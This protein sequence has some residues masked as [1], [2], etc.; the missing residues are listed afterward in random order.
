MKN[1]AVM[2]VGVTVL[3]KFS[4]Q[5]RFYIEYRVKKKYLAN[6]KSGSYSSS[7]LYTVWT[8]VS[9]ADIQ[10]LRIKLGMSTIYTDNLTFYSLKEV[11]VIFFY[12]V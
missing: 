9:Q 6:L 1:H 2:T 5:V 7:T 11:T 12:Y 8:L 10:K 4:M 3:A